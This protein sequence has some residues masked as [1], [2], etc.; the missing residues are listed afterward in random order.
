MHRFQNSMFVGP[1]VTV[2]M[3]LLA[4]YGI[5]FGKGVVIPGYIRALMSVSYL[6]YGLEG[7][8]AAIYHY[9]RADMICPENEVYCQYRNAKYLMVTMGFESVHFGVSVLALIFFYFLF[10]AGAFYLIRQRLSVRRSSITAVAYIGQFVKQHF[11]L[12]LY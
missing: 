3:M 1:V 8:I 11:N 7:I 2:P 6:R 4:V 10:N 9:D 5:G 12:N